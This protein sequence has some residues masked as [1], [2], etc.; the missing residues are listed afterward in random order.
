VKRDSRLEQLGLQQPRW[1]RFRDLMRYRVRHVLLVSS[2]YDSF[3]LTEDGHL[4]EALLRQFVDL[5]ISQNPDLM[6]VTTGSEAIAVA[7]RENRFD[8]VITTIRVSDMNAVELAHGLREAGLDIPVVLLA[9]NNRELTDFTARHDLSEIER[10]F[11]WQ[12][13]VRILLAIV[14]YIEDRRNLPRDTGALGVPLLIVVEDNV[15]FYSSFLPIIYS[16]L[17]HHTHNV[18][19]EGLNLSQKTMRM[20]ARPKV[21]LCCSFEEA[22]SFFTRYSDNTMGIISDIEFPWGGELHRTAGLELS[23]RVREQHPDIPIVL[24]SSF[25]DNE[26]LA[27]SVGAQFLLKGSPTLL[28]QL[29]RILLESFGFGDFVFRMPDGTEIDRAEDLKSLIRK[30]KTVPAES[31]AFHGERNHFSNWLKARTEFALAGNLRPRKVSEFATLEDLRQD[32]IRAISEYRV[33]RDRAVVA[34]FDRTHFDP[35]SSIS[36]IGSGSLG[37]KARGLAFA[38]RLLTEYGVPD[39]FPEARIGVPMSVVLATDVFE[40]YLDQ[41]GLREFAIASTSDEETVRRFHDTPLPRE[42]TSD[43]ERFLRSAHF[44]LAVRSSGLLEDSPNQPF[45]GVYQTFMLPND[46]PDL[47]VRLGHLIAA[48][49]RVYASTFSRQAKSFLEMT[50][51]RLEEE[52]MAVIIQRIIG[53]SHGTRFYPDVSGVARSY[54]FYPIAPHRAE[55]GIAAVALGM[56][57]TVVDGGVCLRFSPRHPRHVVSMS[58]V[59][60]TL[61]N[62][63]RHFFALERGE[64]G[65]EVLLPEDLKRYDLRAAEEDGTLATVGSTYSR[66]NHAIYEGVSRDGVRLVTFAPILK[67]DVFPL[68]KILQVLLEIGREGTSGDVE[69]EFAVNLSLPRGIRPEFGFLQMRP[70]ALSAENEELELG[71]V[72]RENLLCRS[73]RVLGHGRVANIRDVVVV[74][75]HKFDRQKSPE[76]AT[77]VARYNAELLE[78]GA[79]YLLVGVGRWGSAD[80]HLGIPVTWNQISGARVIVEA[81][82]RDLQVTPSQGTHFFQNIVSANVGYFTVSAGSKDGFIDWEWLAGQPAVSETRWVRHVRLEQPLLVKMSGRSGEGVILKRPEG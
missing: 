5:N 12:G 11:L 52:K 62:S 39:L 67:H 79:P 16:E 37:G 6:R 31:L 61:E 46:H 56:G 9:F 53:S 71:E 64:K 58:S 43:L 57:K 55:D 77:Q 45:A 75:Y 1:G 20:R 2:L 26:R 15:R 54:N 4:N 36:R 24:Q 47:Q 7:A 33:S 38:N 14:K 78:N 59:E 23:A 66:D 50:S 32:L 81:G 74:D 63:Q 80:P 3:I 35:T 21:V 34:D 8:L 73:A 19:R 48:V 29:R 68:A 82:F 17:V 13:D 42:V 25:P 30:L 76:V 65:L 28:N 22:W 10:V 49:K 70:L 72:A 41:A 18:I 60:E 27:R 51:Y 40:D 44:P 69:I